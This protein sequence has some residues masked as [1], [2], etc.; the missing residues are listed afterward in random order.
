MKNI[1]NLLAAIFL[2]TLL[3]ASA[4][5]VTITISAPSDLATEITITATGAYEFNGN[6]L[7]LFEIGDYVANNGPDA[8]WVDL[9]AGISA[10]GVAANYAYLD[11]DDDMG[12]D[13]FR[14]LFYTTLNGVNTVSG[15]ATVDLSGIGYNFGHL[16]VGTYEKS[17]NTLIVQYSSVPDTGSTAALLGAGVVALAFARRRLG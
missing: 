2:L 9:S 11:H 4:S 10:G 13:D 3:P 15:S 16:N 6:T 12:G 5:A 8:E 17:G 14:F 7:S 1:Q